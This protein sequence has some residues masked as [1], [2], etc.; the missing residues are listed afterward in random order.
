[1]SLLIATI[2]LRI[3]SGLRRVPVLD[4]VELGDAVDEAG[5]LVAE[6]L[7]Q[8]VHRVVGVLDGVVQQGGAQRGRCHAELGEDGRDRER[9]GDVGVAAAAL[10]VAV[11][12]LGG[13]VRALDDRQ[14][15]L[16]VRAADDGE[17]RVQDRVGRGGPPQAGQPGT[18]ARRR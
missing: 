6:V 11:V 10:L 2:I 8:D 15:G 3:V 17:Q 18:Y 1:M 16:G 12:P 14:V 4:L 5:D 9:V 7:A 13:L